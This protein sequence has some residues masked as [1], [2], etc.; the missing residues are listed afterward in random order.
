MQDT[1]K[2]SLFK[3]NIRALNKFKVPTIKSVNL[4][5]LSIL[6]DFENTGIKNSSAKP[7]KTL[8]AITLTEV[9]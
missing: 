5:F 7:E 6:I 1:D 2:L 9:M 3:T 4:I 8:N